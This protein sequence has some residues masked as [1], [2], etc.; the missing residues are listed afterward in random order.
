[1]SL[2]DIAIAVHEE[3]ELHRDEGSTAIPFDVGAEH[4]SDHTAPP[5]LCWVIADRVQHS[6]DTL[7]TGPEELPNDEVGV[8]FLSRR[9]PVDV[10]VFETSTDACEDLVLELLAAAYRFASKASVLFQGETWLTE[11]EHEF[12]RDGALCVVRLTFCAPV[13]GERHKT[14]TIVGADAGQRALVS[15]IEE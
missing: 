9:I 12:C 15:E 4:V 8:P 2:R 7:D 14:V 5:R 3:L 10:L 6:H 13:Y 1:M 11:R